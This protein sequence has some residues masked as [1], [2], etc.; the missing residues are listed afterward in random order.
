LIRQSLTITISGWIPRHSNR[1]ATMSFTSM[2]GYISL[3]AITAFS[4]RYILVPFLLESLLQVRIRSVSPR[5]V[6]GIEWTSKR[7]ECRDF[8]PRLK[9]ERLGLQRSKRSGGWIT[10]SLENPTFTITRTKQSSERVPHQTGDAHETS[11]RNLATDAARSVS[12]GWKSTSWG[13][14]FIPR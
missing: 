11:K 8:S 3:L 4:L 10:I 1:S 2:L 13:V 6:R 12:S 14:S 5:S 9:I 7:E